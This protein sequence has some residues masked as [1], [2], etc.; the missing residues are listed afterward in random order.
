MIKNRLSTTLFLYIILGFSVFFTSIEI[1]RADDLCKGSCQ[2][3]YS[4]CQRVCDGDS[5]CL[6]DCQDAH[7]QCLEKCGGGTSHSGG[8]CCGG[9]DG[10]GGHHG[11]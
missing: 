7:S 10:Y 4:K 6:S 8:S 11:E 9:D 5:D 3:K 1:A 2:T